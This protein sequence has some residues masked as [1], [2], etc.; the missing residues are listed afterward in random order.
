M[1]DNI[2][3]FALIEAVTGRRP[4]SSVPAISKCCFKT[5]RIG[6]TA[7][8]KKKIYIGSVHNRRVAA[9][10]LGLYNWPSGLLC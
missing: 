1:V 10:S 5:A 7:R 9:W 2:K 3:N 8:E 6:R 4:L